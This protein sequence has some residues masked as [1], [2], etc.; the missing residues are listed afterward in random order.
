[1]QL[2]AAWLLLPTSWAILYTVALPFTGYYAVLYGD[3]FRLA[4]RRARTFLYLAFRPDQQRLLAA[5][6]CAI[7]QEVRA[8][9]QIVER[10]QKPAVCNRSGAGEALFTRSAAGQG[11]PSKDHTETLS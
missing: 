7:V 11:Q 2:A 6:G 4:W 8:L 5:E 9:G 1:V 10:E 3:R